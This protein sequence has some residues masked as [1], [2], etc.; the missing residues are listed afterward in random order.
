M[1]PDLLIV[2][3]LLPALLFIVFASCQKSARHNPETE[4][5]VK[6]QTSLTADIEIVDCGQLRT[7]SPGGWGAPPAGNNPGTY[8]HTN[9]TAAF[10]N[11][12][13]VGCYPANYYVTF[14]SAQ[15]ITRFLPAGGKP[16]ALTANYLNPEPGQIKN[17]L[18][19]HIVALTLSTVFDV[20]DN[21]FGQ[22]DT[23]LGEMIISS[24][25]FQNFTVAEFLAEAN[26]T[27]GGC[28]SKYS[29]QQILVT[30]DSINQ[31]FLD[32]TVNNGYLICPE[33]H[34]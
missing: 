13:T 31:N 29:P 10:P 33:I 27:L 8:L 26:K 19:G 14:T 12:L 16:A 5:L 7:Q 2:R 23:N 11:G 6:A 4:I 20:Y 22:S 15:A 32:G 21:G 25:P 28:S 18:A 30:A 24:G 1:K 3:S 34:D 9:F 17:S